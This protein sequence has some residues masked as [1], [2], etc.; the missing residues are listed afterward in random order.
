M[1]A[2]T[3]RFRRRRFWSPDDADFLVGAA[4]ADRLR[5]RGMAHV[6]LFTVLLFFVV[7][8]LWARWARLDEVTR[9]EAKVIPSRQVQVVQN[10]EGGIVAA[11]LVREGEIVDEGQVLARIDNIRAASDYREK[12]ARF[13]A[14]LAASARLRAEIDGKAAPVFPP[15]VEAEAPGLAENERA[16][17][18][19]RQ[20]KLATELEI[21]RRQAEQRQQELVELKSRLVQTERS[22][23]L[24]SQ[25]LDLMQSVGGGQRVVPKGDLLRLQRQVSDLKGELEQARLAIPRA[26]TA[27]REA[28]KRIENATSTFRSDAQRELNA[29]EAE[30]AGLK[31]VVTAGED[32]VRRTEV[33]SPVRGT[34][35]T[36]KVN[37]IGGVVQPGA[38]LIEIVP[39]E[40]TLLVE[41]QIRPADIAF[42][43]PGLPAKVKITAYDFSIYGG[44]EGVVEDISADT[45]TNERGESF[46]RVRVRTERNHLGTEEKPLRIIPG[47]TAQVDVLTGQKTVLDY[48]LKPILKARARALTER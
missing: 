39:L 32:R 33:R 37:T 29:I 16:L 38:D 10:L 31:E 23:A 13:L 47:M 41:A 21:L 26:E 25:E 5:P 15:E 20:D 43:S 18:R 46:Y 8:L 27:L 7:F 34:I 11:M 42:L 44:L 30:M 12:R 17:F 48:L 28:G 2:A 6:L 3:A 19:S 40:D 1:T 22:F 4:A 14:L 36:I 24:A 35:K 45:I 9:G